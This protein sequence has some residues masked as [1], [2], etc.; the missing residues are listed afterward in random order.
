MSESTTDLQVRLVLQQQCRELGELLQSRAPAGVGFLLFLADVGA[1]GSLAYVSNVDRDD[2]HRLVHEWLDRTHANH[3]AEG[4]ET[5]ARL[6]LEVAEAI[7]FEGEPE[8]AALLARCKEL[9]AR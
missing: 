1:D 9:A 5:A 8:P 4:W 2:A 6:L 7:G 3:P